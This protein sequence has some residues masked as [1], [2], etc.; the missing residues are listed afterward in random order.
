MKALKKGKYW[1][2]QNVIFKKSNLISSCNIILSSKPTE[3]KN[4]KQSL[5][6]H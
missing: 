1:N 6:I 5:K 3:I 2:G 4:K